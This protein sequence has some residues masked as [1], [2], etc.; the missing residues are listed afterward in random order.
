RHVTVHDVALCSAGGR[1]S[2]LAQD[3]E[4][5]AVK[6]RGSPGVPV[7]RTL[8]LGR[9][10]DEIAQRTALFT[11]RHGPI[12][13]VFLARLAAKDFRGKALRFAIVSL[14]SVALL[15][16]D[17]G[18]TSLDHH[19]LVATDP[20]RNDFFHSRRGIE[21]PC[22]TVLHEGDRKRPCFVPDNERLAIAALIDQVPSFGSGRCKH[23]TVFLAGG[24]I[25]SGGQLLPAA[26]EEGDQFLEIA[27]FDDAYQF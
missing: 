4:V 1:R 25:R 13:S 6:S 20:A 7:E 18:S 5:V 10:R 24:R 21:A 26:A 16:R 27:R 14:L 22:R 19:E 23:L 9:L 12:Q 15:F 17:I 2:L 3:S 8:L 11:L